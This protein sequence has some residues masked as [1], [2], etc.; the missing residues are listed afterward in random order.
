M[1]V[2]LIF[3][4]GA[5]TISSKQLLSCT[6]EAERTLFQTHYFSKN[7]VAPEIKPKPLDP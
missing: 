3:W 4:T 6:H 1:A 2:L 5:A 7:L